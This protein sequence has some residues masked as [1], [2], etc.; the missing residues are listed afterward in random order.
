[1][2]LFDYAINLHT[3]KPNDTYGYLTSSTIFFNR[4][5]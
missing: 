1:M 5:M 3:Y 2:K 4:D